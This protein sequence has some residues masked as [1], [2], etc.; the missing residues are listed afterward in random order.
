MAEGPPP[1]PIVPKLKNPPPKPDP[2][3]QQPMITHFRR[4]RKN[5]PH[6]AVRLLISMLWVVLF[7]ML[8]FGF[9]A[10]VVYRPDI[11]CAFLIGLLALAFAF[12]CAIDE[13]LW[14]RNDD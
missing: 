2:N 8:F 7:F 4:E 14:T 1:P 5:L 9:V 13:R 6:F 3:L 10:W 12:G 11:A